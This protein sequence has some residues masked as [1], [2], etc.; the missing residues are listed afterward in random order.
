M[1]SRGD[2]PNHR[3]A[4]SADHAAQR[5]RRA[6]PFISNQTSILTMRSLGNCG[7]HCRIVLFQGAKSRQLPEG[8]S[9]PAAE[10]LRDE[11]NRQFQP[12]PIPLIQNKLERRVQSIMHPH[13]LPRPSPAGESPNPPFHEERPCENLDLGG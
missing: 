9:P 12:F 3:T 2:F 8:A 10:S 7:Q 6:V 5:R 13:P 4:I 11:S 1:E